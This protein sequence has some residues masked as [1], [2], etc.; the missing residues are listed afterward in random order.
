MGDILWCYLC[1]PSNPCAVVT[2]IYSCGVVS[3]VL[4]HRLYFVVTLVVVNN[5]CLECFAFLLQGWSYS[6]QK[7]WEGAFL[8]VSTTCTAFTNAKKWDASHDSIQ[9]CVLVGALNKK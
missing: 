9:V 4:D 2:H 6:P 1:V 8:P 3:G 7:G 5:C